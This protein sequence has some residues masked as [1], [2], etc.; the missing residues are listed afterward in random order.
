M[1]EFFPSV[2]E[3]KKRAGEARVREDAAKTKREAAEDKWQQERESRRERLSRMAAEFCAKSE[4]LGRVPEV[5]NVATR[6]HPGYRLG[7]ITY[8]VTYRDQNNRDDELQKRIIVICDEPAV[9]VNAGQG[10]T[11][12]DPSRA[13]LESDMFE[14]AVL[15]H[16][17]RLLDPLD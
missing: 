15:A 3:L 4:A 11:A 14:K 17:A 13:E 8:R 7:A 1:D 9:L 6:D 5:V 2:D 12:L 10:G 16:L